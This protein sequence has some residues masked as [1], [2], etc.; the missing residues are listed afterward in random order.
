MKRIIV[1]G[2]SG[3]VGTAL[4]DRLQ[5]AGHK[6]TAASR[7]DRLLPPGVRHVKVGTVDANTDWSAA[8]SDQDVLIHLAAALPSSTRDPETF[9]RVNAAGTARI[10]EQAS[11]CGIGMIVYL[12][13]IAVV[14]GGNQSRTIISDDTLPAP[15]NAYGRSKLEAEK[16]VSSFASNERIAISLRPP[17]VYGAQSSG[18]WGA[19]LKLAAS[20]LPLPFGAVDNRRTM[21][22][23]DALV[24]AIS[25]VIEM[26]GPQLCGAYAVSDLE[27]VS[28][29]QI[30]TY[31]REGMGKRP[32]LLR[33]PLPILE[34]PLR[35]IGKGRIA[36]SLFG[37]LEI[38]SSRFR[39]AFGWTPSETASDAMRRAGRE[40]AAI[41]R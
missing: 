9:E 22:C 12:S 40:F 17:L 15:I 13:S 25:R 16:A 4:V 1:T 37:D 34:A 18:N 11:L 39:Q 20:S 29:A 36:D 35:L 23:V 24:G 7:S 8:M 32:S 6:I 33:C 3:M 28:L 38:D 41:R 31:L 26:A 30:M 14:A 2:A 10:V 19:L 21:I 27:S 5:K